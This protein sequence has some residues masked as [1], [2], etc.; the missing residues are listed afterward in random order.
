V[1]RLRRKLTYSNVVSTLCLI[2]LVGGGSAY[3]ATEVLPVNS[4]GTKQIQEGA[5]TPAKLSE[6]AKDALGAEVTI[7]RAEFD[8]PS[9]ALDDSKVV[10]KP[11]EVA[12]GGGVSHN[13]G[14]DD[15]HF[16]QPGGIPESTIDK[17]PDK[18]NAWSVV[19][20]NSS[21]NADKIFLYVVCARG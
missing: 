7:R 10:C 20:W 2:L 8:A 19:W 15:I 13:G 1:K 18:P 6:G 14:I 5:V 3:A 12:T 17:T 4:V 11:G 9:L 16:F 21:P